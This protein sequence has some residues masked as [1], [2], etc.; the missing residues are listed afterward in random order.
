MTKPAKVSLLA[1]VIVILLVTIG[2]FLWVTS[3]DYQVLF[4]DLEARD[5]A[6]LVAELDKQKIEYKL[7]DTGTQIL[8]PGSTVHE[9]RLKLMGSGLP[10]SGGVGFE[11]FDSAD[12]GMTEF[13][14]RI[15]YQRA[16]EGELTR[17]IMTLNEVKYARVHLVLPEKGL[18]QKEDSSPTASVTLFLKSDYVG[19]NQALSTSQIIGIQ[20][21]VAASVPGMD[22]K[23][24][25]VTDQSGLTLSHILPQDGESATISSKLEQKKA[26]E[27]YLQ[28]KVSSLL[29]ASLGINKA[30]VSVDVDLDFKEV[31][32]TSENV[33]DN[34]EGGKGIIRKR[35]TKQ[36]SS[37]D[38]K[39][40]PGSSITTDIEY[41]LGR[42]VEQ[43][44]ET[45][46][47]IL[48]LSVGVAVPENT[49]DKTIEKI[50]ELAK[51]AVGFSQARGDSIAVHATVK[52]AEISPKDVVPNTVP[53]P[54]LNDISQSN[55][56]E[57]KNILVGN[58]FYIVAA[59][60]FLFLLLVLALLRR[61]KPLHAREL[62]ETERRELLRRIEHWLESDDTSEMRRVG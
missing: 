19:D 3:E 57:L 52:K 49:S 23:E 50:Q 41:K 17:T 28:N 48:H 54:K 35:E 33:L 20:R 42:T 6:N 27:S 58:I 31:R 61:R 22:F 21:L 29:A 60:I 32:H 34:A 9:I 55:Y 46:G 43:T 38:G 15:N 10:M 8:V 36:P 51:M 44:V 16:L 37:S 40:S 59:G 7:D 56:S 53:K 30:V 5:A 4:S 26:V 11:I 18:F 2:G 45:P 39:K 24:V 13:A 12:F 62:T 25:T 47:S 14:Q 1:G